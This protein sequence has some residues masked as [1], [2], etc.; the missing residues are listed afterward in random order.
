M[1]YKLKIHFLPN[2]NFVIKGKQVERIWKETL[3]TRK[4]VEL[5]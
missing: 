4:L 2:S 5:T 1:L 3:E